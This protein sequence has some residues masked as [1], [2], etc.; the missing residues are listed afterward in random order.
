MLT[1]PTQ[2]HRRDRAVALFKCGEQA[3]KAGDRAVAAEKAAQ[4]RRSL[5]WLGRAR[6]DYRILIDDGVLAADAEHPTYLA[7]VI[8]QVEA[9]FAAVNT[10]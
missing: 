6:A 10:P 5:D 8:A 1:D 9:K 7:K 2:R 3:A 4:Y